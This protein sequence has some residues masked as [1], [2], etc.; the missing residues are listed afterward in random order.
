M[1]DEHLRIQKLLAD[2]HKSATRIVSRLKDNTEDDFSS[3]SGEDLRDI[4]ARHIGILGEAS[5]SL[6]K[7]HSE[8]CESHSE[9]PFRQARGLR[10]LLIHNYDGIEWHEVW[11]ITQRDIPELLKAIT[12]YIDEDTLNKD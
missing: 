3:P 12:P 7:K 9:I 8:F 1:T 5:A 11:I 2:I 10:N 6:L 4:T